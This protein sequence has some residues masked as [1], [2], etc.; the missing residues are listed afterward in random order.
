MEDNRGDAD[1]V[2]EFIEESP[3]QAEL[4]VTPRLG[5]ALELLSQMEFDC[6]LLD[7]GLPDAR[8]QSA[9][10]RFR[11]RAPRVPLVVLTGLEDA[12]TAQAC[13]QLGAQEYLEKARLD[14]RSLTQAVSLAMLR[15]S[16]ARAR[17][18]LLQA[19]RLRSVG[20]LAAG[21]AHEINNPLTYL[22]VNLEHLQAEL[23]ESLPADARSPREV[24]AECRDGV[25]R[26]GRIVGRLNGFA[27]TDEGTPP[28]LLHVD[29]IVQDARRLTRHQWQ[30]Y[31]RYEEQLGMT[32]PVLGWPG[33]LTQVLVNLLLNAAHAIGKQGRGR[34]R[35]STRRV[36]EHVEIAVEDDGPG[37]LP[38]EL[39]R[40]FD[41]FFTTKRREE[42]TGL[43]LALC[44]EIA[45]RHQGTLEAESAPGA[46]ATFVLRIP[47]GEPRAVSHERL[48]PVKRDAR[49][50][51][52]FVDDEAIL[53]RSVERLLARHHDLVMAADAESAIERLEGGAPFDL[54]LCDLTMPGIG[55]RGL[56]R[57]IGEQ[58][59][60][61]VSRF[62]LMSGGMPD[63]LPAGLPAAPRLSKPFRREELEQ[64]IAAVGASRDN[65]TD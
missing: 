35:V 42:G 15:V 65:E 5:E 47:I 28:S 20:L 52:L 45:R 31:C 12:G 44:R 22:E 29:T 63:E 19:D 34:I 60:E 38:Y 56:W 59:P 32:P 37:M 61:L 57:W 40:A 54:V 9:V 51:I 11:S 39:R 27:R 18:E 53:R 6:V 30:P 49:R 14:P 36:G 2:E 26:I 43:G 55:G 8:G 50:R 23:E 58:R 1:L 62:V 3:L 64:V 25:G 46:G 48:K 24:V 7:L 21:V 33:E 13:V 4:V 16:E 10:K 17:R 41:P